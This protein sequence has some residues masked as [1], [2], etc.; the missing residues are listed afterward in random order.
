MIDILIVEPL[1]F[2][3]NSSATET[4]VSPIVGETHLANK[5]SGYTGFQAG[6]NLNILSMGYVIPGFVSIF[7]I[8]GSDLHQSN[9]LRSKISSRKITGGSARTLYESIVP[10]A[11]YEVAIGQYIDNT[12]ETVT[13]E[14]EFSN[15]SVS[16]YVRT[17]LIPA[18]MNGIK[19]AIGFMVKVE[20]NL[21]MVFV[22]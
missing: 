13:F 20:H 17:N 15:E 4:S 18:S 8:A 9:V 12:I 19:I 21:P 1:S 6:D 14:L 2:V 3:C 5:A 16:P 11:P 7:T 22:P 10:F